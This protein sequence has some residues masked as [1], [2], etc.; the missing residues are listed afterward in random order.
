MWFRVDDKSAFH[1]KVLLAGNSAWGVFCR[2]GA[3]SAG[4]LTDGK[5]P[6]RVGLKIGSKKTWDRL[7]IVG[8]VERI[9]DGWQIHDWSD[10]NPSSEVAKAVEASKR[11]KAQNAAIA[12]WSRRIVDAPSI[13]PSIASC[14]APSINT[15]APSNAASN[16]SGICSTMP[17]ARDPVPSRPVQYQTDPEREPTPPS[18]RTRPDAPSTGGSAPPNPPTPK[19]SRTV[20]SVLPESWS[21]TEAHYE[22]ASR[23]GAK[24]RSWVDGEAARMRDWAE[25]KGERKASWDAAFRNWIRTALERQS[26]PGPSRPANVTPLR[27]PNAYPVQNPN[28]TAEQLREH[29]RKARAASGMPPLVDD[30]NEPYPEGF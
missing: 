7:E 23:E 11:A 19:K 29:A 2:A 16:A 22:Q 15:D 8:L 5:I 27:R 6:T 13:A 3:W 1:S 12:R 20:R 21:P 25:S 18:L 26:S 30:S 10:W 14:T 9:S 17:P 4:E 24:P 28:V